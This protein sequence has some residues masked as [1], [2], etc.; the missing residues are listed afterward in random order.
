MKILLISDEESKYLY[1]YFKKENFEDI[2]LILSAGDLKSSYLSF[3]VT[4]I[5]VPLLYIHGNHDYRYETK[6]PLGCICIEDDV[7][8]YKGV[9]IAGIG[10]CMEYRGGPH[11]YTEKAMAKKV[12]KMKRKMKQ[13]FDILLTHSPAYELGDGTDRAHTGFKV[14]IDIL[15]KYE[16]EYM[17]HGHQH[18]NYS[19]DDRIIHY[20]DTTIVNAFSYHII[21]I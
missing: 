11:Q 7:Y 6:P 16:P 1:D 3:L 18:L 13:G 20:K 19:S 15:D 10:G 17:I 2:D 8:E 12:K 4:M 21:E 9:K 14:F 5:N